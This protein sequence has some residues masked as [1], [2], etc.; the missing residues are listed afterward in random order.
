MVKLREL[1]AH[2][3]LEERDR[4]VRDREAREAE[5]QGRAADLDDVDAL[6]LTDD[7]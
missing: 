1:L 6:D 4:K 2:Y 7:D 3:A 5:A